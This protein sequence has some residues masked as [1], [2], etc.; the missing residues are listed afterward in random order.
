M[1]RGI[2]L[3]L[4]LLTAGAA[5]SGEHIPEIG[6]L[7]LPDL[8]TVFNSSSAP[9]LLELVNSATLAP[10]FRVRIDDITFTIAVSRET[11]A[12]VYE[13]TDSPKFKTPEGFTIRTRFSEILAQFPNATRR[14]NGWGTYALLPSGWGAYWTLQGF[15][16]PELPV[17]Y[18]FRRH[19]SAPIIGGPNHPT[20][21][22]PTSGTSAAGHPP[23]QP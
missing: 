12:V 20:E 16:D 1:K 19:E 3:F 10:A 23:R 13:S 18:F 2:F 9:Q 14:E 22:T 4:F 21:P 5:Y 7:R 8:W 11:H 17:T 6:Y 15:A